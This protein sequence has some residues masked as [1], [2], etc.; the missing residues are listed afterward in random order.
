MGRRGRHQGPGSEAH[1]PP[2][3]RSRAPATATTG[4]AGRTPAANPAPSASSPARGTTTA[5][6]AAVPGSRRPLARAW[7]TVKR[8]VPASPH[9]PAAGD[10]AGRPASHSLAPPLPRRRRCSPGITCTT[11]APRTPRRPGSCRPRRRH[12]PCRR[13]RARLLPP[14]RC[15]SRARALAAGSVAHPLPLAVSRGR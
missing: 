3:F 10:P 11:A 9:P 7:H 13:A 15:P 12:H 2:S 8:C 1:S 14:R 6:W 5:S 4:C